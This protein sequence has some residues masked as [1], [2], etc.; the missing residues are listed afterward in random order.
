MATEHLKLERRAVVW[1]FV[2][3]LLLAASYIFSRTVGDSLFLA[4]VGNQNLAL[5]FVVSG[6][7]TAVFASSWYA[8]TH[9][10]SLKVSQRVSGSVFAILSFAAWWCLPVW[11][12]SMW[13][14]GGIYLLAEVKGC[15]NAIN[16][17]SAMSDILGSHSRRRAWARVGLGVPVAGLAV[18][19]LIGLEAE[20][21]DL[22]TWLLVSAVLDLIV[23]FP[24]APTV[25]LRVPPVLPTKSTHKSDPGPRTSS[26]RRYACSRQFQFW[27]A[28]LIACKVMVL[29]LVAF[30]WKST[31]NAFYAGNEQ[32]LTRYFGIFYAITGGVTLIFQAFITGRL[33]RSRIIAFPILVM[34]TAFLMLNFMFV[35][36]SGILFLFIIMTFARSVETWRRSVHDTTINLLYTKIERSKRRRAIAINSAIVKPLAEVFAS[37]VLFVGSVVAHKSLI[38]LATAVWLFATVSLLR[39]LATVKRSAPSKE[40]P[41]PVSRHSDRYF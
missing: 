41:E 35:V 28:I 36:G 12:H 19:S 22:R 30:E 31:V 11:H 9:K 33:L 39:L 4:R 26:T 5:V 14:L 29:T 37:L 16:V 7:T 23:A 13:L 38:I 6:L 2:Y 1:L 18:G 25:K 15:V 21:V 8:I 34:P 27:I 40:L 3:S 10:W 32:E 17:I 24:L 20:F